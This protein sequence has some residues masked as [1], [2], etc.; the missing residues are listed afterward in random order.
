MVLKMTDWTVIRQVMMKQHIKRISMAV[1][2][3]DM[4]RQEAESFVGNQV[5][6]YDNKILLDFQL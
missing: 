2:A 6:G 5:Q 4:D 1:S 3:W